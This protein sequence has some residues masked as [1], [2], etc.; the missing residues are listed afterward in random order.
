MENKKLEFVREF[1]SDFEFAGLAIVDNG[2]WS[3]LTLCELNVFSED[4]DSEEFMEQVSLSRLSTYLDVL[5]KRTNDMLLDK[6]DEFFAQK[7]KEAEEKFSTAKIKFK[8]KSQFVYEAFVTGT[9]N[10]DFMDDFLDVVKQD[11]EYIFEGFKLNYY[12]S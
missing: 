9:Y 6:I 12:V 5:Q 1:N 3:G 11:F 2:Y 8:Y 10:E 4:N 7:T